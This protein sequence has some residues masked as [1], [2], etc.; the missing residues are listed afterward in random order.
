VA[1]KTRLRIEILTLFPKM[2]DSVTQASLL[3]RAQE[4]GIVQITVHDLRR[5]SDDP[6]HAK[7]DDRPYGGGAGM[8]IRPEPLYLALKDL[9][10]VRKGARKPWV[11]F[12]S[13]QGRKL[14]QKMAAALARRNRLVLI[15]G[16][17]EGIDERVME[18]V[19]QEVSVGDYVLTGGELPA[20]VLT[21]A[22]SRL[23]PGVVGDPESVEK[24]SF[25]LGILD[26]PHYT[27]PSLWRGRA[28][29]EILLSGN[30]AKIA[31]WRQEQAVKQ[32][33]SKRPELLGAV[34]GKKKAKI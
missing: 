25:S 34:R 8:V 23:V 12:L 31:R 32:T 33:R 24:D 18:W 10:A 22:V 4:A 21:D 30:H 11:V 7:V 16:R 9:G 15:C 1:G 13:P 28:V 6:R 26:H 27:R 29:P 14:D 20:M 5:W 2:F 19:D 3:G 17:Y